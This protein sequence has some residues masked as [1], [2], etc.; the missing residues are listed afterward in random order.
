[1][2]LPLLFSK[3]A[4]G[5]AAYIR[6]E[7]LLY[8][9]FDTARAAGAVNGT[10]AEPVGGARNVTDTGSKLSIAGGVLLSEQNG[11]GSTTDPILS[12]GGQSRTLGLTMLGTMTAVSG[13]ARAYWATTSKS[14][15]SDGMLAPVGTNLYVIQATFNFIAATVVENTT[16]Q[17]AYVLRAAGVFLFLKGGIYTNW[18]L[19][20]S[21]VL[22]T[23]TTLYPT[24]NAFLGSQSE[25]NIRVPKQTYIPVPLQSDGMSVATT[26][27]LGN[28]E[29]NGTAGNAY[30]DVGTWG[31]AAGVRSCSVLGGGSTGISVLST[32]TRDVFIEANLTRSAGRV[33]IVARYLNSSNYIYC[34]HDGTNV[35]VIQVVAGTPTTLSTT[36]VAY[37]AG[38][39]MKF[40]ADGTTY[41]AFY[42]NTAAGSGNLPDTSN[43]SHGLITNDTGNTFD[44]LVIWA[45]N[46]YEGLNL[47]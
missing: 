21:S 35:L 38:A 44:N 6:R 8:D 37:S 41:R 10:L 9:R 22:G 25:D 12:Y 46:G 4:R 23:T 11:A 28:P 33:G 47:L 40:F 7:Y 31:V 3:P 30:T 1:M 39:T 15:T 42:N 19:I 32:S 20:Y 45:R 17:F 34:A 43:T 29:N 16:Y 14:A 5:T 18:T 27:G 26:D 13:R 2:K 24:V 36:A